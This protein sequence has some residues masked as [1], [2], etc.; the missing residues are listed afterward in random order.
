[1]ALLQTRTNFVTSAPLRR[2][3]AIQR[4]S[5]RFSRTIVS[6]LPAGSRP[7]DYQ[8]L[9]AKCV[10]EV[11]NSN[12][13][14][15]KVDTCTTHNQGRPGEARVIA[16]APANFVTCQPRLKKTENAKKEKSHQLPAG[17]RPADYVP[18]PMTC[19]V[20]VFCIE[21]TRDHICQ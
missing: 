21:F 16:S 18:V 13:H 8:E 5:N 20:H 17:S 1:M 6:P 12:V 7:A 4:E 14:V 19:V 2:K 10:T 11:R 9:A 3:S 15:Y